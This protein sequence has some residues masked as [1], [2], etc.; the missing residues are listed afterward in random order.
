MQLQYYSMV[1]ETLVQQLGATGAEQRLSKSLF[2]IVIGSNDLF[3]YFDSSKLRN[4]VITPQGYVD[5]MIVSL[6]EQ[7]KL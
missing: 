4:Q 5:K 3:G 7:L 1:H 6:K 2:T